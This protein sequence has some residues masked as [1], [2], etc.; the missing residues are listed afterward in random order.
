LAHALSACERVSKAMAAYAQG[1]LR[2]PYYRFFCH[3]LWNKKVVPTRSLDGTF[4]VSLLSGSYGEG[5]PD[6]QAYGMLSFNDLIDDRLRTVKELTKKKVLVKKLQAVSRW[7]PSDLPAGVGLRVASFVGR[8]RFVWQKVVAA[9]PAMRAQCDRCGCGRVCLLTRAPPPSAPI[10]PRVH[11][12]DPDSS[13]NETDGEDDGN[14]QL[15]C[16]I[17]L[18]KV[19]SKVPNLVFCTTECEHQYTEEL[20]RSVPFRA[21]DLDECFSGRVG[22]TGLA[23]VSAEAHACWLR[24]Q[25]Q[26]RALREAR[27][28]WRARELRTVGPQLLEALHA[29]ARD[30]LNLDLALVAAAASVAESPSLARG[31]KLVGTAPEWRADPKQWRAAINRVRVIYRA[32]F[33]ERDGVAVDE[34]NPPKW[35][36]SVLAQA[37]DI[38]PVG[39]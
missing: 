2:L 17:L 5:M 6:D 39:A 26:A 13:S 29:D 36:R 24:N 4:G 37:A 30:L 25:Q 8:S 20:H 16:N 22:R 28:S 1:D 7:K 15:F 14:Q 9:K 27:R 10:P 31:R 33:E 11:E 12:G 21:N 38:F 19:Q 3:A 18:P 32:Y 34:R 35:L 23:R